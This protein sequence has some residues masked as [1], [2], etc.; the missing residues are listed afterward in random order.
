MYSGQS[1]VIVHIQTDICHLR[2][3]LPAPSQTILSWSNSCTFISA[4][5]L[6]MVTPILCLFMFTMAHIDSLEKSINLIG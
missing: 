4:A 6:L 1:A 2:K 5:L 3:F